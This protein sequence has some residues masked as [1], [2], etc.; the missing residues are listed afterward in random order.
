MISGLS[1]PREVNDS[2][3]AG[4]LSKEDQPQSRAQQDHLGH[5][6][7][8]C[9]IQRCLNKRTAAEPLQPKAPRLFCHSFFQPVQDEARGLCLIFRFPQR[10]FLL[11]F[12]Q[13]PGPLEEAKHSEKRGAAAEEQDHGPPAVSHSGQ[14]QHHGEIR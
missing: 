3:P 5:A 7:L 4:D 12:R 11:R 10:I 14:T 9:L 8:P 1:G 6:E 2:R 13:V